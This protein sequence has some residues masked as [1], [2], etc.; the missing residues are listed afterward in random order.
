MKFLNRSV[1]FLIILFSQAGLAQENMKSLKEQIKTNSDYDKVEQMALDILKTGFNAGDGYNQV[2]ARD[3]NTFIKYSCRVLPQE[4]IRDV[5]LRFFYFQGFDGNMVDGY[6]QVPEEYV[7]DNY[8]VFERYD[9]PGYV[10]HKNTVETDQETSLIQAVYKYIDETGDRDF[11]IT[12]IN[13]MSVIDRMEKMLDFLMKHRFNNEY[14]LIWGAATADWGDVQPCHPWGVKLDDLSIPCIDIYD[15]A[16]MLIALDNF[17]DLCSDHEKRSR[18]VRVYED[19]KNNSR[20]HLWDSIEKKFIPH[21]YIRCEEFEEVDESEIY[22]H[23]GTIVAIEAGLL[24]KD[25]VNESLRIMRAN[26]EAA[27]AMSVGLTMYPPYPDGSFENKGM[28]AYQYQ[29]GGDWTWFGARLIPR[30]VRYGFMEEAI[31]ELEPFIKRVIENDGFYE[32][33]TISGE[34]RGSGTFRGSAGVLLEAIE[35][36]REL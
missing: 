21:L 11:L 13:G 14:G 35:S 16:M 3:L 9:M 2:W 15:N 19:I 22:Y 23:G 36:L 20:D 34:P 27:G 5:L 6:E 29:N 33:Y 25:E 28:G 17:I 26:V 8:G 18:W 4:T 24:N 31:T 30:L 7:V 1:L 12:E 32:W 10:F